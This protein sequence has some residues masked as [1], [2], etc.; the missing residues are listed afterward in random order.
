VVHGAQPATVD[1]DG[2]EVAAEAGRFV[3]PNSG[4]GFVVRLE[5]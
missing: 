4:Q 1:L 2:V 5:V 3:L